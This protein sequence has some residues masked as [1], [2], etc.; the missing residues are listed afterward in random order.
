MRLKFNF[1][2][3]I[4]RRYMPVVSRGCQKAS[5]WQPQVEELMPSENW[6]YLY[7]YSLERPRD[8]EYDD[9]T[10]AQK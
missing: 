10:V 2:R 4:Q 9:H 7:Q 3:C 5:F 1:G 8:I 6:T